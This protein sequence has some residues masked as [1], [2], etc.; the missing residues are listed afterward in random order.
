MAIDEVIFFL[1]IDEFST[2]ATST[3]PPPPQRKL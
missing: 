3:T 1:E 2:V